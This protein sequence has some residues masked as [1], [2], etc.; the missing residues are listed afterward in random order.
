MR[1]Y[2]IIKKKRD[3]HALEREEI[4]F[5][6][7]GYLRGDVPD[8]QM[9][10]FLMSVFFR[11]MD[12]EE[13]R[14]LTETM[15][16]SGSLLDLSDIPG[17]KVDKH[18]TGGVGDKVSIIL[19]PLVA[20]A[21]LIVPMM[22]G[23]GLG[24]TGGT[25]DKLESIPGFRTTM[26]ND[27]IKEGLRRVGCV[28]VG[29]SEEMA[30]LDRRLYTL[31]D[32][33]ATVDSIPLITASIMSKKLAEGI[34]GLVLDV[35]TGS[36]AF[37]KDIDD[38]RALAGSMVKIGNSMGVKTV[39]VI[40]DMDEPLGMAVGNAIEVNEC[41]DVLNGRQIDDLLEVTLYL[42]AMMLRVVGMEE[43]TDR[44]VE[45]LRGLIKDGSALKK[46][47]EMVEFQGGNP[48]IVERRSL[49]PH[50]C[51]SVEVTSDREGFITAIDAEKVGI[52]SMMLGAGRERMDS[53]IDHAA[54]I[55]L[56]KKVGDYVGR[57]DVLCT[58]CTSRE[59]AV[60][61]AERI[62]LEGVRIGD[63]PPEKRSRILE[64]VA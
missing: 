30:P 31:R 39:A 60:S 25:M 29:F 22:T 37:M 19:T 8:Y 4:E 1:V 45:R 7:E 47:I 6:L 58:F 12:G 28:M 20:S 41:I 48:A 56:E 3:G 23:R 55:V 36:G 46:F 18:S 26:T 62:F 63:T 17:R 32:V 21:G 61:M 59:E 13:T 42:G 49:L 43:E 5:L 38:A 54:G 52:A 64:V 27:E 11:G 9:S 51:L 44:A 53:D 2:E 40:T 35:K 33:T 16:R 50:S 57:D 15:L 24:H 14:C 10:A 34:D